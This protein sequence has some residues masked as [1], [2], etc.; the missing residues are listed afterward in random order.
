MAKAAQS[1]YR[2]SKLLDPATRD[3]VPNSAA[4]ERSGGRL[5]VKFELPEHNPTALLVPFPAKNR[6]V[7]TASDCS[8]SHS[9][10]ISPPCSC[11]SMAGH[12]APSCPRRNC[13][14]PLPRRPSRPGWGTCWPQ[15]K[16]NYWFYVWVCLLAAA[17]FLQD[18]TFICFHRTYCVRI[19]AKYRVVHSNYFLNH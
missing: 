5:P 12:S 3:R 1:P 10:S 13:T 4:G 19:S 11:T 15:T 6:T 14:A 17:V 2:S 18:F 8:N 16:S 7:F 9:A